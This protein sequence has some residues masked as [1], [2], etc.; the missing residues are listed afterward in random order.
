M[1]KDEVMKIIE[2]L[3]E[4]ISRE[5]DERNKIQILSELSPYLAHA[6]K[7]GW[8]TLLQMQTYLSCEAGDISN[9][10]ALNDA[11]SIEY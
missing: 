1:S 5:K 8:I 6:K 3:S 10:D 11:D 2:S 9:D 7:A 4:E